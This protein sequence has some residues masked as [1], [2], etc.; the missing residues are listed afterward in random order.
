MSEKRAHTRTHRSQHCM[1]AACPSPRRHSSL[2]NSLCVR[3]R[4]PQVWHRAGV[5]AAQRGDQVAPRLA[6]ERLPCAPGAFVRLNKALLLATHVSWTR[7]SWA[8]WWVFERYWLYALPCDMPPR[9]PGAV[10]FFPCATHTRLHTQHTQSNAGP[11]LLLRRCWLL[12]RPR[13][14]RRAL[15]GIFDRC[16]QCLAPLFDQCV[17]SA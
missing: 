11:L 15:Q 16:D 14:R 3:T 12:H 10:C 5:H 17:T 8:C 7:H 13:H 6:R 1:H 2:T 9:Q 4:S